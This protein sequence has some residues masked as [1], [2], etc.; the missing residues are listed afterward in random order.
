[1]LNNDYDNAAF[2]DGLSFINLARN[3]D[4]DINRELFLKAAFIFLLSHKD[5]LIL[6][7]PGHRNEIED[8]INKSQSL[9]LICNEGNKIK[10]R[11]LNKNIRKTEYK[12]VPSQGGDLC[13][14]FYINSNGQIF[15][16]LKILEEGVKDWDNLHCELEAISKPPWV[17][18]SPCP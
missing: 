5:Y 10:H 6:K 15:E 17:V 7:Y 4:N 8:Y 1:M 3:A 14:H 18:V 12:S 2:T 11:R 16:A 13:N 9:S